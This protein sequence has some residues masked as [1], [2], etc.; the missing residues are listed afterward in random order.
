MLPI[1]RGGVVV[2]KGPFAGRAGLYVDEDEITGAAVVYFG[3]PFTHERFYF[4]IFNLQSITVLWVEQWKKKHADLCHA[5]SI[6]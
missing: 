1:R 2:L 6:K 5:M 3:D 4:S